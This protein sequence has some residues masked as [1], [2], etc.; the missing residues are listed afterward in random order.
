MSK[1]DQLRVAKP[2]PASWS[3]MEGDD[4]VRFCSHCEQR[5]YNLTAMTRSEAEQLLASRSGRL[6]LRYYRRYDGRI[7]TR[8]CPK[9]AKRSR[10]NRVIM[11]GG[12]LAFLIN[13]VAAVQPE[14]FWVTGKLATAEHTMGAIATTTPPKKQDQ[15]KPKKGST[16]KK[17]SIAIKEP[18]F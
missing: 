14:P 18:E 9:G 16:K 2:C 11:T 1:L 5:V 10:R 3:E 4:K 17:P 6:C 12:L 13:L 15:K 7:M 8:D